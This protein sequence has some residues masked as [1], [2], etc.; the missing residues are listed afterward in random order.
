M[1]GL[2][3]DRQGADL[4]RGARS[5]ARG[6]GWPEGSLV[7]QPDDITQ[8]GSVTRV[9]GLGWPDGSSRESRG[10]QVNEGRSATGGIEIPEARVAPGD[11]ANQPDAVLIGE[12][13]PVI[14]P[15][16]PPDLT[17]TP[18]ARA[19]RSA[20]EARVTASRGPGRRAAG[21]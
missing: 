5:R 9:G 17:D 10:V 14:I 18:I 7:N 6:V 2:S 8:G 19:S 13:R 3:Y 1:V 16:I 15:E 21:S 12:A 11:E 4:S 20:C